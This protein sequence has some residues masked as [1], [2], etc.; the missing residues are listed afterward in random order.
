MSEK[1]VEVPVIIHFCTVS[2]E[3]AQK[4]LDL[5]CYLSFPG[6]I[7]FTDMYDDSVRVCPMD[8]MLIETDAPFAAP[9]PYRGKRNEPLYVA[10]VARRI[11]IIQGLTQEQVTTQTAANFQKVF[12]IA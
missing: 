3:L 1:K 11:A 9:T 2:G 5:G 6:P 7:T 10:E 12:N 4:Y 8:K